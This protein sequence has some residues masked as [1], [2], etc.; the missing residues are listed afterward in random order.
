MEIVV[1]GEVTPYSLVEMSQ[2]SGGGEK[3][4]ICSHS[5]YTTVYGWSRVQFP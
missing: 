2:G 4:L 3:V 1:F 5:P